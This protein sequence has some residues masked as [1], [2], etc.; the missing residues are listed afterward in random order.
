VADIL[1]FAAKVNQRMGQASW[2]GKDKLIDAL[3]V[4]VEVL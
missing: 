4:R 2:K 3:N 1:E